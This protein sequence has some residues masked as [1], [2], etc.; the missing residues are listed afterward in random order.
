MALLI[1]IV[2]TKC[3]W[4]WKIITSHFQNFFIGAIFTKILKFRRFLALV[5]RRIG[6]VKLRSGWLLGVLNLVTRRHQLFTATDAIFYRH[7]CEQKE[8]VWQHPVTLSFLCVKLNFALHPHF[9]L[10]SFCLHAPQS[11]LG[12]LSSDKLN[13]L[14]TK[15][16][17]QIERIWSDLSDWLGLLKA[18]STDSETKFCMG[19]GRIWHF[20]SEINWLHI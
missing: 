16:K 14:Y 4:N 7:I 13:L 1:K 9:N 11:P 15:H 6:L 17:F 20:C 5:Q 18:A 8:I 3:L 12:W 19:T 2:K 10:S